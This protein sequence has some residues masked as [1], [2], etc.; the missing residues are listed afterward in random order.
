MYG[1]LYQEV[2]WFVFVFLKKINISVQKNTSLLLTCER[3]SIKN[4]K[5]VRLQM[6]LVNLTG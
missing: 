1:F 4:A 3:E 6:V 2:F 5:P